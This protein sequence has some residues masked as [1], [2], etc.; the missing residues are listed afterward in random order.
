MQDIIIAYDGTSYTY[1]WIKTLIWARQEFNERDYRINYVNVRALF[2]FGSIAE[3]QIDAV[4]KRKRVDILLIAYHHSISSVKNCNQLDTVSILKKLR[5]KCEKIIWLDTADSS[6]T[7]Q[8]EVLPYV[9]FYLKKQLLKDLNGYKT[10]HY[11]MRCYIDYYHKKYNLKDPSIDKPYTLLDNRY[12]NKLRVSFNVG[13]GDIWGR[14]RNVI[15]RPYSIKR[16][17][18]LPIGDKRNTDIF[19]NGTIK[20]SELA[21]FQRRKT[22]EVITADLKHN[23]PSPFVKMSHD[24]YVSYMKDTKAAISPFGWGEICYRDFETIAYGATLLK[25][26]M[27]HL[28]TYPDIYIAGETYVPLYWDFSNY[29]EIA[30]RIGSQEY[31]EIAQNAQELFFHHTETKQGKEEFVQHFLNSIMC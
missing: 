20:Y 21:G 28:I 24:E 3:N 12:S 25:P 9:D 27:E 26:S 6:G 18:L 8:F 23:H 4:F 7:T 1:R 19:F 13:M 29:E 14:V 30:S 17:N 22:C 5:G 10:H 2:P 31:K 11:G 16:P 15:L